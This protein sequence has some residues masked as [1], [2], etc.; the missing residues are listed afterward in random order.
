MQHKGHGTVVFDRYD[1][2]TD[3]ERKT[4]NQ[5]GWLVPLFKF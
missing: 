2:T 1:A 3:L 4:E 5:F